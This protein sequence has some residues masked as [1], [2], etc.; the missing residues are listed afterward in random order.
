MKFGKKGKLSLRFVGRFKILL[1]LG[2]GA[3][4]L[5]IPP[6]LTIF[7]LVFY[8]SLLHKYVSDESHVISYDV[9]EFGSNLT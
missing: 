2:K 9:V 6:R 3:Y 8:V 5:A 4:E 1:R 7:H